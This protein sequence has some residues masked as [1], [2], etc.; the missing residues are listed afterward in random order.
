MDESLSVQLTAPDAELDALSF[1]LSEPDSV[2]EWIGRLPMANAS[3]AAGQIR[4]ATFEIARLKIDWPERMALIEGIR[5]T[6]HYL[7]IRLD[8]TATS[9]GNQGDAIARLAQ[10]L[11]TNL[12]SG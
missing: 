1:A 10:R 4:Q 2:S 7:S 12:C 6:L 3:E 5:P 8:K 9:T 11:Q